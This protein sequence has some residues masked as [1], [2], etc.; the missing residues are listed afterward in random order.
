MNTAI[1]SA[2]C[3]HSDTFPEVELNCNSQCDPV[4]WH[5]HASNPIPVA[6]F[7]REIRTLRD[8]FADTNTYVQWFKRGHADA[9]ALN[10]RIQEQ[11]SA[12]LWHCYAYLATD[13]HHDEHTAAVWSHTR[14]RPGHPF[15]EIAV[16]LSVIVGSARGLRTSIT[17]VMFAAHKPQQAG[18]KSVQL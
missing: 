5:R 15:G 4:R 6:G 7:Y 3:A 12:S 16:Y 18:F 10:I 8:D 13:I 11:S 1:P 2:M 14:W 17:P 9:C